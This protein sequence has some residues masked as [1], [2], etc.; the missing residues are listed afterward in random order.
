MRDLTK[1]D[2]VKVIAEKEKIPL[3]IIQMD[4]DKDDSV[5]TTFKATCEDNEKWSRIDILV[6]NAEFGLCGALEDQPI[7]HIKKQFETN[8]FGSIRAI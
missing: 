3:K 5:A 2:L 1:P 7:E 4:V 8:L 6:N